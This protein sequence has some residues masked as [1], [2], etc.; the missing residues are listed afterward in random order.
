MK[1]VRTTLRLEEPLKKAA[2]RLA[3]ENKTT[4]QRI[5][6]DSLRQYLSKKSHKKAKRLVIRSRDLG[7]SL[8]NLTREDYYAD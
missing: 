2:E 6:N 8:D 7:E 5:F 3:F 1:L 4:L